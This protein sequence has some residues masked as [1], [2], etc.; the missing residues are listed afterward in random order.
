MMQFACP[1]CG[2][3]LKVP[4]TAVGTEVSCPKC[5]TRILLSTPT[6]APVPT[7]REPPP[8]W[9]ELQDIGQAATGV[10]LYS[11]QP[12]SKEPWYYRSIFVYAIPL[13]IAAV[14]AAIC[15]ALLTIL[16]ALMPLL[17]ASDVSDALGPTSREKR[18]P[19]SAPAGE[20]ESRSNAPIPKSPIAMILMYILAFVLSLALDLMFL[21]LVLAFV[22]HIC[23]SVDEARNIRKLEA[24][25]GSG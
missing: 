24:L 10:K 21:L 15:W 17:I 2:R 9:S 12:R 4:A 20:Q 7:A 3:S 6:Q 1:N 16:I 22:D 13:R 8:V 19:Y 5:R 23:T 14:V 25:A 11:S 18:S